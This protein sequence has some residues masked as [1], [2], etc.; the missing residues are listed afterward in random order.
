MVELHAPISERI[1]RTLRKSR[2]AQGLTR[3]QLSEKSTV[4]DRQISAIELGE[5]GP[6]MNSLEL[7]LRSLGLSADRIFYPELTEDDPMMTQITHLAATCT[8]QQKR[9]VIGFIHMLQ[10]EKYGN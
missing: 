9:M 4:S 3:Q 7:L 2:E 8:E 6:N 1:G 5:K 10:N